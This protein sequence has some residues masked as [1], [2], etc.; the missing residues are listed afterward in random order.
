MC[1]SLSW[2]VCRRGRG[3]GVATHAHT[4]S[5]VRALPRAAGHGRLWLGNGSAAAVPPRGATAATMC[6]V[7]RCAVVAVVAL[8]LRLRRVHADP[9]PST[10]LPAMCVSPCHTHVGEPPSPYH[11]WHYGRAAH[12]G[13]LALVCG[14]SS[15]VA[16]VPSRHGRAEPTYRA[17]S[18]FPSFSL[19]FRR[20]RVA[21]Q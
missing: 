21:S 18:L 15:P 2:A 7:P 16:R 13:R 14:P 5:C 4:W 20:R 8:P 19:Y 17:V 6:L 9:L 11:L 3:H 10:L 12:V 1:V